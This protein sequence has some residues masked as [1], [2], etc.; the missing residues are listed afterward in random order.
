MI[1]FMPVRWSQIC[2]CDTL[3]R[4]APLPTGVSAP[5]SMVRMA[6]TQLCQ[7]GHRFIGRVNLF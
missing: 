4:S 3:V 2:S 5:D 7:V 6:R 1:A